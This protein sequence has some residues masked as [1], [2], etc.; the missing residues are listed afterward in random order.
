M[1]MSQP[2][3]KPLPTPQPESDFYWEKAREHELWLRRC[4]DCRKAFFY[5][6]DICPTCFSRNTSWTK[7]SG[8]GTLHTFGIVHRAPHPGFRGDVPYVVAI[9]ELEDGVRFP[10]NLVGVEPDPEAIRIGMAVAVTFD[11][12]TDEVTLP[13]FRTDPDG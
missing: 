11:D 6:R 4:D 2:Y 12:V 10:T 3:K 8:R 9:V 13:K 7:S 1:P 5:P